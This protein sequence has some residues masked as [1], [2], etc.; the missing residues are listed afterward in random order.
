M[1]EELKED[2]SK[3][4]FMNENGENYPEWEEKLLG[5]TKVT[6]TTGKRD[7]NEASMDGEYN[8]Y[9]CSSNISKINKY[10]FEGPSLLIAGNGVIGDVKYYD[11]KFD[12]Y[13]RVYVL[14]N[15]D[16]FEHNYLK[17]TIKDNLEKAIRSEQMGSTLKYIRLSTLTDLK[18][19]IPSFPE[20]EKIANLLSK[21]D[22][23]I[24]LEED[25]L[26]NT[27]QLK[28]AYMQRLLT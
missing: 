20:Q 6:F 25:S 1:V 19:L 24:E 22:K 8:F 23:R 11:N 12:A 13:Q 2:F 15:L 9:T 4:R 17:T 27:K 21:M 14:Q 18:I 26:E 28:Q 7:A 16:E 5:Q 3:L 10:S